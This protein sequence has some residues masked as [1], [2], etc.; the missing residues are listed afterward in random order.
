MGK[1]DATEAEVLSGPRGRPGRLRPRPAVGPRHPHRRAGPVAVGRPAPAARPRPGDHR[2]PARARARRPAVRGRRAHRGRR[3]GGPAPAAR[4]LHRVHR[5]PPARRRWRWPTARSCS[6]SGRL[7][8]VGTHHDLLDVRAPLPRRALRGRRTEVVRAMTSVEPDEVHDID[9]DAP[10]DL[11]GDE[12]VDEWRGVNVEDVDEVT[13][14]LAGL[15][16]SREPRPARRPR[17]PAPPR[18]SCSRRRSSRSASRARLAMPLARAARHR[19]GHPAAAR[20]RQRGHPPARDGRRSRV[21]VTTAISAATF[22]AFLL[23]PRA[24]RP[25]RRARRP[26]A[27]LPPLPA[28]EH[29]VPRALHVGPGDLPPDLR[30][31]GH[32]RPARPR[33]HQPHHLGAAHRRHRRRA[34]VPGPPARARQPRRRSRSCS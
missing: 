17:A 1:P 32:R 22:N 7:V 13:G 19:R 4:G 9:P 11:T 24:G 27:P 20:R 2:P 23:H 16:R 31:R 33:P 6:T 15:L 34:A 28:A 8:A 29:V 18:R 12:L 3:P 21:L 25:G 30:R 26:R 5:R 10:L 14:G